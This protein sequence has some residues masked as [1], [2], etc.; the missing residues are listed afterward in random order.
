MRKFDYVVC[1]FIVIIP[2]LIRVLPGA[3]AAA[4]SSS[5]SS[6]DV[7]VAPGLLLA[8]GFYTDIAAIVVPVSLSKV[9]KHPDREYV[10]LDFR[11]HPPHLLPVTDWAVIVG[12]KAS[13]VPWSKL[14]LLFPRSVP[15]FQPGVR[16]LVEPASERPQSRGL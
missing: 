7:P 3:G 16:R 8:L 10:V 14:K 13:W 6:S 5:S 1:L 15:S 11:R 2:I 12:T 9:P 4:V